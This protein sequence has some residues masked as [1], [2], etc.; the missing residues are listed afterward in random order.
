MTSPPRFASSAVLKT[1]F[2]VDP[3][4][5]YPVLVV[6][7]R[8]DLS[9]IDLPVPEVDRTL[10][11]YARTRAEVLP[12]LQ[13]PS[14]HGKTYYKKKYGWRDP[15]DYITREESAAF[16]RARA[17]G[18]CQMVTGR[19]YCTLL[20]SRG[21]FSSKVP[22]MVH[23]GNALWEL[24]PG[25]RVSPNYLLDP[26]TFA[27]NVA[28]R[29]SAERLIAEHAVAWAESRTN[30]RLTSNQQL[31]EKM[32][33]FV[34]EVERLSP[35]QVYRRTSVGRWRR[36]IDASVYVSGL[37]YYRLL[38]SATYHYYAAAH[39]MSLAVR[40]GKSVE[41]MAASAWVETR[42]GVG[43]TQIMVATTEPIM[44]GDWVPSLDVILEARVWNM[45]TRRGV[46][47]T[48]AESSLTIVMIQMRKML[49]LALFD[50]DTVLLHNS[51]AMRLLF[52]L[53][54]TSSLRR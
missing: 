6:G 42:V 11:F 19:M 52:W 44:A 14:G 18:E 50:F 54:E 2:D 38:S 28:G 25:F 15:D 30:R 41:S 31:E 40:P 4:L 24:V 22:V 3:V 17:T 13:I 37:E 39:R 8:V 43:L 20:L 33:E 21:F 49:G 45:F 16:R 47:L 12:V 23:P 26:S 53:R 7:K 35:D 10:D 1:R 27:A 9:T 46:C 48:F 29:A 34:E 36:Y 51:V 32:L 5:E